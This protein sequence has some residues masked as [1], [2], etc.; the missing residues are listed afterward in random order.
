MPL[1]IAIDISLSNLMPMG[2]LTNTQ[3]KPHTLPSFYIQYSTTEIFFSTVTFL[4]FPF[5]VH[6]LHEE[7]LA[8]GC[9]SGLA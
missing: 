3:K 7:A 2:P 6:A 4:S 5:T 8:A 9:L 1:L